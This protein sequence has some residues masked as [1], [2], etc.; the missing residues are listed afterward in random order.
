MHRRMAVLALGVLLVA[1]LMAASGGRAYLSDRP[2]ACGGCHEMTPRIQTWKASPHGRLAVCA[3]CHVPQDGALSA[4]STKAADGMRHGVL[5]ATGKVPPF[6][7]LKRDAARDVLQANCLRCHG[8]RVSMD[9]WRN[10]PALGTTSATTRPRPETAFHAD[11]G[12]SCVDCHRSTGHVAAKGA[13]D[14]HQ[15]GIPRLPGH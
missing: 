7:H 11:Q 14:I 15:G 3:D 6:I 1:A 5:H 4:F 8:E 10:L 13:L 12:R 9:R 2:E